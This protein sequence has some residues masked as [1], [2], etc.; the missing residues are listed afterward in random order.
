MNVNV[1]NVQA[2]VPSRKVSSSAL[3]GAI[4][5]TVVWAVNNFAGAAIPGEIASALTTILSS[6]V[7]YVV[8]E[9]A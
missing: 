9:S 3:A 2:Y 7:A 6:V 8:P 4:S 5:I 1:Q